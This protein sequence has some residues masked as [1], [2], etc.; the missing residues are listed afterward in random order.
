[1][2]LRNKRRIASSILK[3]GSKRV[4][5][6]PDKLSE[7]K[8]AI[9]KGDIKSLIKSKA[10]IPKKKKG[11]SKYRNRKIRL[12]KKKGRRKG[13]GSR[14]GKKTARF[15]SKKLWMSKIRAQRNLLKNLKDKNLISSKDYKNLYLKSKG[16]FFRSKRHIKVYIK[17]HSSIKNEKK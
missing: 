8:E 14:K 1:M 13:L 15:P 9:T 6:D 3:V 4:K 7:I 5:F 10:V 2:N 16:G 17:E 12:Q 11:I